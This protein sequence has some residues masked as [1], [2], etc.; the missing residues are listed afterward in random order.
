MKVRKHNANSVGIVNAMRRRMKANIRRI[1]G[2]GFDAVRWERRRADKQG[3]VTVGSVRYRAG[4]YWHD[5]WMLVGMRADGVEILDEHGRH[6]ATL[7]R[8]WSDAAGTVRDPAS[9]VPAPAA[10]FPAI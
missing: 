5:R 2:V 7:P 4:P 3:C 6:A 1:S 10:L 8:A 9:P